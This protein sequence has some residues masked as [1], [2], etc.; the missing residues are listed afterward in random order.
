MGVRAGTVLATLACAAAAPSAAAASVPLPE[1][2]PALE[3]KLAQLPVTSAKLSLDESVTGPGS[4]GAQGPF[5]VFGASGAH[6]AASA[7]LASL[8]LELSFSEQKASF[9]GQLIG[10]PVE[11][12]VLA[13][14][15]YVKSPFTSAIDGGRPWVASPVKPGG[16]GGELAGSPAATLGVSKT[17]ARAQ[18]I[19]VLPPRTIGATPTTGFAAVVPTD[20]G[21][22]S[23]LAS[24]SLG[25]LVRPT[26][27]FEAFLSEEG[28][29]VLTK[30]TLRL[31]RK[32]YAGFSLIVETKI[33]WLNQPIAAV[34]APPASETITEAQL[35]R[36]LNPASHHRHKRRRHTAAA[37]KP[38]A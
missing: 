20:S 24:P 32:R 28:V 31:R 23:M 26:A 11:G 10:I 22:T 16:L 18:S 6:A 35:S 25:K 19:Q 29:P 9:A 12:R 27:R 37:K 34:V 14:E 36:L 2:L 15:A 38:P 4:A 33:D 8:S 17:F 13:G 21:E 5:G 30:L 1:P 7:A 3:A